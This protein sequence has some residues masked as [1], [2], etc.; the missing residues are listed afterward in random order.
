MLLRVVP[1]R[2]DEHNMKPFCQYLRRRAELLPR[3][4]AALKEHQVLLVFR[5]VFPN[6]HTV[7]LPAFRLILSNTLAALPA[8]PGIGLMT[9][10]VEVAE[11]STPAQGLGTDKICK[12]QI[13]VVDDIR[14]AAHGAQF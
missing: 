7:L 2:C 6:D 14:L 12:G 3:L 5:S 11:L 1:V 8:V 9:D 4:T 13:T 10:E